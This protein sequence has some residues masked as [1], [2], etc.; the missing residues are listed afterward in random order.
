KRLGE[1]PG[2]HRRGAD[3]ARLAGAHDV[4]QRLERLLDRRLRIPPVNLVEIDVIGPE[5]FQA[6]IDLHVDRLARET[7]AVRARRDRPAYLGRDDDLF[8]PGEVLEGAA[9]D[10]FRAAF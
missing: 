8:A 9:D 2:I 10:L 6:R 3:I 1:L 5:P 7:D 4:V